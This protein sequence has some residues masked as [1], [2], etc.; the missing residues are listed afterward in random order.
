MLV[1]DR[2]VVERVAVLLGADAAGGARASA[3]REH[4]ARRAGRQKRQTGSDTID[5]N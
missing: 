1:T 3:E 5:G 2:G 4:A